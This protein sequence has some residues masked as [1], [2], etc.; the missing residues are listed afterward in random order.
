MLTSHNLKLYQNIASMGY[1]GYAPFPGTIAS[2]VTLIVG[3][4]LLIFLNPTA[5]FL[6][7]IIVFIIGTYA[8]ATLMKYRPYLK[9]P[10]DYVIDECAGQLMVMA[11]MMS[12]SKETHFLEIIFFQIIGFILFRFFDGLKP[13]PISIINNWKPSSPFKKALALM[14]D[15]VLA[16]IMSMISLVLFAVLIFICVVLGK[17]GYG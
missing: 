3:F 2:L 9:D 17:V 16:G 5:I 6:L 13:W 10:R 8:C 15:D 11:F 1:I 7:S 14:L 12:I 4:P